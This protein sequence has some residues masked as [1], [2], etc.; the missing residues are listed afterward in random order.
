MHRE[1]ENNF[2]DDKQSTFCNSDKWKRCLNV[3]MIVFYFK[4]TTK[5]TA[6]SNSFWEGEGQYKFLSS[7]KRRGQTDMQHSHVRQ[8]S[9]MNTRLWSDVSAVWEVVSW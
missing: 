5:K 1:N 3:F 9:G 4:K 6:L 7:R 2:G 8:H